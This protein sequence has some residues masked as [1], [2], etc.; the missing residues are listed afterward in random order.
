MILLYNVQMK[1]ELLIGLHLICQHI[2]LRTIGHILVSQNYR[3]CTSI[4][5]E[6]KIVETR[7]MQ[8]TLVSNTSIAKAHLVRLRS[9]Q[10]LTVPCHLVRK[11]LRYSNRTVK[12]S[13]KA[14]SNYVNYIYS[15]S[16]IVT[17]SLTQ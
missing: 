2:I 11:R 4:R 17:L 7:E 6:T 9:S 13:I 14:V 1:E 5:K 8:D 16:C 15:H 10:K 12:Y 3:L